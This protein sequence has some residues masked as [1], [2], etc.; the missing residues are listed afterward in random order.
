MRKLFFIGWLG[1]CCLTSSALAQSTDSITIGTG[2]T[3]GVYYP[4]GGGI[5]RIINDI[6]K[7]KADAEPDSKTTTQS[8]SVCIAESTGGTTENIMS[9]SH[10]QHNFAIVQEDTL[11]NAYWGEGDTF[12][13]KAHADLRIMFRLYPEMLTVIAKNQADFKTFADLAGKDIVVGLNSGGAHDALR[14]YLQRTGSS[15]DEFA[16]FFRASHQFAADVLCSGVDANIV[17]IG[18][19]AQYVRRMLNSCDGKLLSLSEEVINQVVKDY[20]QYSRAVLDKSVYNS[21]ENIKTIGVYAVLA[22]HEETPDDVVYQ[23]TQSVFGNLD[24]L[25]TAHPVLERMVFDEMIHYNT[26]VP[27]HP[28]VKRYFR[29]VGL[30]PK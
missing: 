30:M 9:L 15:I 21:A 26:T 2:S 10:W 5:C 16:N 20:P 3:A 8:P 4:T 12:S 13:K 11:H 27:L 1:L 23:I 29:D 24:K 14:R 18:H 19:P 25:R 17:T 6:L 22:T 7:H 28:A